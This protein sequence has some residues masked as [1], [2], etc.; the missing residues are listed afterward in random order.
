MVEIIHGGQRATNRPKK[1]FVQVFGKEGTGKTSL[2]LSFPPPLFLINLDRNMDDL[3]ELL[4]NS[5]EIHY[6]E[7]P[8]DVDMLRGTSSEVLL[9]VKR[10]FDTALKHGSGTFFVDGADLLWEYVKAAK[11]P[12]A[13]VPNQWGPANSYME[14]VYRRAESCPL[15]VVFNCIASNVWEGMQK[16]TKKMKPDGFKHAG[17]FINTSVYMFS[18]EDYSTPLER[19]AAGQGQSHSSFISTSKLNE[20]IVGSV[21]SNLSYMMLYRMIFKELPPEHELL[22]IPGTRSTNGASTAAAS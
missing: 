13:E 8:Y 17:R 3:L 12:D 4:P 16:E 2:A 1:L 9:R 19:P 5:Y 18:P 7:V 15:Q 10:M 22:W 11:V 14:S 21:V 6:D 20:A